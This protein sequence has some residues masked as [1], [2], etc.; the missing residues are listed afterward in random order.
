MVQLLQSCIQC[1]NSGT[2]RPVLYQ[3]MGALHEYCLMSLNPGNG[4]SNVSSLLP[5]PS[6]PGF[7]LVKKHNDRVDTSGE[8]KKD[9]TDDEYHATEEEDDEDEDV[10]VYG[11]MQQLC[12]PGRDD[13]E[14][15]H[16]DEDASQDEKDDNMTWN[17]VLALL[18]QKNKTE[19]PCLWITREVLTAPST[20]AS[21]SHKSKRKWQPPTELETLHKIPLLRRLQSC[22]YQNFYGDHRIILRLRHRKAHT[23]IVLKC[24]SANDAQEWIH[25]LEWWKVHALGDTY[26]SNDIELEMVDTLDSKETDDYSL[27]G[28]SSDENKEHHINVKVVNEQVQRH[29]MSSSSLPEVSSPE[30]GIQKRLA[31][32]LQEAEDLKRVQKEAQERAQ[33]EAQELAEKER[34]IKDQEE[35]IKHETA[36]RTDLT[37]VERE[38]EARRRGEEAR[39]RKEKEYEQ[40]KLEREK[41]RREELE[42]Q[43]KIAREEQK[44]KDEERKRKFLETEE[45]KERMKAEAMAAAKAKISADPKNTSIKPRSPPAATK[46]VVVA[47]RSTTDSTQSKQMS[48]NKGG[49]SL[50]FSLDKQ[51]SAFQ[52]ADAERRKAEEAKKKEQ[53]EKR[54]IK[55]GLDETDDD[56]EQARRRIAEQARQRLVQEEA[57]KARAPQSSSPLPQQHFTT[58][59]SHPQSSSQPQS[60]PIPAQAQQQQPHYY[61]YAQD[62]QPDRKHQQQPQRQQYPPQPQTFHSK[63]HKNVPQTAQ[64]SNRYNAPQQHH[65]HNQ[66]QYQQQTQ[67]QQPPSNQPRPAP[68]Q[69][70]PWNSSRNQQQTTR[71]VHP[72]PQP[73]PPPANHNAHRHQQEMPSHEHPSVTN[74]K[75]AAMASQSDDGHASTTRIK[76]AILVHWAL[77]PP[78]LHIL[79]PI[80]VLLSTIHQIFPPALGVPGHKYF[81]KWKPVMQADVADEEKLKK[82]VRKLRFFL[83]PDK[84][85]R[86]FSDEQHFTCKLLWDVTNDAFEDYKKGKE[87]LDWI[88]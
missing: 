10:L 40:E 53:E 65:P 1:V 47:A 38:Q 80:D 19:E 85:P 6:K 71:S 64:Q 17:S 56:P 74:E 36:L 54:K 72:P 25:Q 24:N 68:Q 12:V 88:K 33:K 16:G 81:G 48:K 18:V 7:F 29:M 43:R 27:N 60:A 78:Q 3:A 37:R 79:R 11:W 23:D 73:P 75:Y 9:D 61:Q 26:T 2:F 87:D 76:H 58:K 21:S 84:L 45:K 8:D 39:R 57:G 30:K 42:S 32:Q 59:S 66:H 28:D 83:H 67:Y 69:N 44:K 49:N 5:S 82:A 52:T 35:K 77:L 41:K 70:Q 86:E 51:M 31:E 22:R 46:P 63:S 55:L 62:S 50:W 4:A 14:H 15:D 13:D 34:Q 20:S